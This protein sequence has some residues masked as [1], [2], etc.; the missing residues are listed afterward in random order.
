[1]GCF[2]GLTATATRQQLVL[3]RREFARECIEQT[4]ETLQRSYALLR[5]SGKLVQVRSRD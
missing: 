4:Y 2:T 3:D 1:M 5:E